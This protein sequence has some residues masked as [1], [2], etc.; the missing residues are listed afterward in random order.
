MCDFKLSYF[1]VGGRA[2]LTRLI[3]AKSGTKFEDERIEFADW[4]AKKASMPMSQLPILRYKGQEL[5]QS[6]TIARFAARKCGL[7]GKEEMDEFLCDQFVSTLWLDIANK[8]VEIF[9]EKDP[10]AKAEKI[11]ARRAPTIDGLNRLTNFVKGDFV[12]GG[13]MSY[14]DLALVDA[15]PWLERTIPD[16]KLPEKLKAVVTKVEADPKISTY[17]AS[18]P[19]TA[20]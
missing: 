13:E 10:A 18:R 17:L 4:P 19:K 11:E 5:I 7:V 16:V 14:A 1:N 9:F 2:E 15:E 20:F 8:L 12:L 3:F 6:L